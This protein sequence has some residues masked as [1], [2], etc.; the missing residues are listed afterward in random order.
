MVEFDVKRWNQFKRDNNHFPRSGEYFLIIEAALEIE[1]KTELPPHR[2]C[3]DAE[4]Q[5]GA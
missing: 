3:L 1:T 5:P 2:S 4:I